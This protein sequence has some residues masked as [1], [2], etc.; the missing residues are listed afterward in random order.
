MVPRSA[1]C[2]GRLPETQEP[3][4]V[5]PLELREGQEHEEVRRVELPLP[6]RLA[7]DEGAD[8][9]IAPDEGRRLERQPA[10][11]AGRGEGTARKNPPSLRPEELRRQQTRA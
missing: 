6:R 5:A 10:R 2:T 7:A 4:R 3:A 1:R 11:P 8:P 9:D